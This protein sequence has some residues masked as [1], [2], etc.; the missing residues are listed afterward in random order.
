M[1]GPGR[2]LPV[3]LRRDLLLFVAGL[4]V[5]LLDLRVG[6]LDL[7]HDVVG[8]GLMLAAVFSLARFEGPGR[9]GRALGVAKG[10]A[11]VVLVVT[12]LSEPPLVAVGLLAGVA[13]SVG[14]V[15][16]VVGLHALTLAMEDLTLAAGMVEPA[17]RWG[18]AGWLV[19]VLNEVPIAIMYAL[20]V[21]GGLSAGGFVFGTESVLAVPMVLLVFIPAFYVIHAARGTLAGQDRD[22]GGEVPA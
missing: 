20:G 9:Y 11:G 10:A 13:R 1:T 19:V 17:R 16:G 8:A 2:S 22:R 14:L 18:C 5:F 7:L 4:L 12:I 6:G 15:L 3:H 21:A